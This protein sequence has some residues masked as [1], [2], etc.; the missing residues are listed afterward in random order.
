MT[1]MRVVLGMLLGLVLAGCGGGESAVVGTWT[2][3]VDKSMK[4]FEEEAKKQEGGDMMLAMM[5]PML[6]S[7]KF[8]VKVKADNTFTASF[9]MG[10]T[11]DSIDGTWE[12]VEAGYLMK[13]IK[14]QKNN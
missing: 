9:E 6:E 1:K 11:K 10:P 12:K 13:R 8:E 3:D 5:K 7:A 2:L 14:V 4:T